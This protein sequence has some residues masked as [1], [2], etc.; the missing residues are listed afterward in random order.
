M[1]EHGIRRLVQFVQFGEGL[2]NGVAAGYNN[3]VIP[4][5]MLKHKLDVFLRLF[6]LN[7]ILQSQ[8]NEY[9]LSLLLEI[10]HI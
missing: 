7:R 10:K 3:D 9:E 4:F 6:Y 2:E 5:F 8:D 1:V